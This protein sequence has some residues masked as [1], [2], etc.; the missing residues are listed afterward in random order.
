MFLEIVIEMLQGNHQA[1]QEAMAVSYLLDSGH[2]NS[3]NCILLYLPNI[4][5]NL[6]KNLVSII[7]SY[8]I[9][10]TVKYAVE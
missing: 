7:I 5:L 4:C 1:D 10:S 3:D 9:E 6:S 8:S 2:Q